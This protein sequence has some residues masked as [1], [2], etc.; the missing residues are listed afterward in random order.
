MQKTINKLRYTLIFCVVIAIA[1]VTLFETSILLPG[2]FESNTENEFVITTIMEL[3]TI[4]AIPAALR[5][6]R[7]KK[8]KQALE[9]EQEK[10]LLRW[11]LVRIF[12]IA[13]PMIVNTLLYYIFELSTTFAYMALALFVTLM[14]VI[15]TIDNCQSETSDEETV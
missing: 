14:F 12:M 1:I 4:I 9:K 11:G 8:V 6:F 3:L 7:F 15:P 5:L 13:L 2:Y 10:A